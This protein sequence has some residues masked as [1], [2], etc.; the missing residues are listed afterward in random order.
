MR[1]TKLHAGIAAGKRVVF[2]ASGAVDACLR[3]LRGATRAQRIEVLKRLSRE[4]NDGHVDYQA[5]GGE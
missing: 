1:S 2:R 4:I 5:Y 3:T